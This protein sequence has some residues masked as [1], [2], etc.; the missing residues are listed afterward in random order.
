MYNG[1]E[2][3]VSDLK[4]TVRE[5][6]DCSCLVP[7]GPTRCKRCASEADETSKRSYLNELLEK[8]YTEHNGFAGTIFGQPITTDL[9]KEALIGVIIFIEEQ[10]TGRKRG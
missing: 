5:C 1:I 3:Y 8:K 7:G 6:I 9:S 4:C 10:M 2:G